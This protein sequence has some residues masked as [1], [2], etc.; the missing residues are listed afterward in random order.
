MELNI[1]P[2][3]ADVGYAKRVVKTLAVK[4]SVLG[5][6][7]FSSGFGKISGTSNSTLLET[8]P[9]KCGPCPWPSS[10]KPPTGMRCIQG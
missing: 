2:G 9:R 5:H 7:F 8:L 10:H 6:A 3:T 4:G 1:R